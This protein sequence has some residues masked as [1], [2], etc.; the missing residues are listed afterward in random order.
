MAMILPER[1]V[2]AWTAAYITGRRWRARLWAPTEKHPGERYDL[3]VGLGNV[4]GVPVPPH[5]TRW[6][7]KVFVFEHK[8]VYKDRNGIPVVHIPIRQLLD[9]LAEDKARN[10]SLVYYLLPDPDW[11]TTQSAPSGT[12]PAVA[13]RRTRGPRLPP[14]TGPA[15]VGF[16]LWGRVVHVEDLCRRVLSQHGVSRGRF[17]F[18]GGGKKRPPDWMC[19]LPVSDFREHLAL[20][21]F[22]SAV[23]SCTHGRLA[24]DRELIAPRPGA[25]SSSD[26]L[27]TSHRSLG[28]ALRAA[29]DDDGSADDIRPSD[30]DDLDIDE[31]EILNAFE[32][33][34]STTF[35]GVGDSDNDPQ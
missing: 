15:W 23:R 16:Q 18:R 26:L 14:A 17:Q 2:D 12:L 21:D 13:W 29:L 5:T 22:I 8:G 28:A 31:G 9:H 25:S 7:D 24:S 30:S 33:P 32:R 19:T 34:A 35:Y 4:A 27:G 6:P 11:Q 3:G 1:T 20:R 10:G